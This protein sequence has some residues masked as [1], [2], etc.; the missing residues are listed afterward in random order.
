MK[1]YYLCFFGIACRLICILVSRVVRRGFALI[2]WILMEK[3][4]K[5]PIIIERYPPQANGCT[6]HSLRACHVKW[7]TNTYRKHLHKRATS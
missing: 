6:A 3:Q 7:S 4:F 1:Y 5:A 2:I